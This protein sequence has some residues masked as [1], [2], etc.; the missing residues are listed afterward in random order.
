MTNRSPIA[1][2]I[3]STITCGIY[4]LFWLHWAQQELVQ[5]G[6]EIPSFLLLFVPIANVYWL[7]KWSEGVERGTSG[8]MSGTSAFMLTF[9]LGP[10]GYAI[11]QDRFNGLGQPSVA[12]A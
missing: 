3:L 12:M 2:F 10:I 1:V 6:A 9:L 5:R 4:S 8:T 11:I 7:W